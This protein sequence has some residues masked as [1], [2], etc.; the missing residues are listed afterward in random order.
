[1]CRAW[2]R[3]GPRA[4]VAARPAVRSRFGRRPRRPRAR[5]WPA[6]RRAVVDGGGGVALLSPAAPDGTAPGRPAVTGAPPRAPPCCRFRVTDAAPPGR[7]P[8]AG[9]RPPNRPLR[10]PFA[11]VPAAVADAGLA[12]GR[13][14]QV[15]AGEQDATTEPL[16]R[17]VD[18]EN[19]HVVIPRMG[20]RS[21]SASWEP[22][23]A[24]TRRTV[25]STV[26]LWNSTCRCANSTSTPAP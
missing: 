26:N 15:E 6:P 21:P 10:G 4:A 23:R 12:A 19:R 13:Q 5:R 17:V 14:L 11:G 9:P 7:G 8:R 24:L 16:G 22:P 3:G 18:A 20:E 1:M 25:R 2:P